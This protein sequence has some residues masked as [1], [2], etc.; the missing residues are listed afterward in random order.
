ME[1]MMLAK[2]TV[3]DPWWPTYQVQFTKIE[4]NSYNLVM[5]QK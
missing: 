3:V 4:H 2:E 1:V 5:K